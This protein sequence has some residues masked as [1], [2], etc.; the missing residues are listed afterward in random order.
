LKS[1]GRW[2]ARSLGQAILVVQSAACASTSSSGSPVPSSWTAALQDLS[3]GSAVYSYRFDGSPPGGTFFRLGVHDVDPTTA[4]ARYGSSAPSTP[5][6]YWFLDIE[7]NDTSLGAH[8]ISLVQRDGT[9]SATANVTLLHHRQDATEDAFDAVSGSV[10]IT[11]APDPAAARQGANLSGSLEADFP[12]HALEEVEC[13]GGVGRDGGGAFSE[14]TC[15]DS[16]GTLSTCTPADGGSNC[17]QDLSSPRVHF[18]LS[19]VATSCP[20]MCRWAA[21]LSVDYCYQY[22]GQ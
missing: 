11:S 18:S 9:A 20:N 4:C 3:S 14:C 1:L 19:F 7:V 17:C 2:S 15:R 10:A 16:I 5:S 12:S 6:D 22:F 13:Q 8:E 21:G